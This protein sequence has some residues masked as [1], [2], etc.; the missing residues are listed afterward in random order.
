[1]VQQHETS[2]GPLAV[3]GNRGFRLYWLGQIVSL[4]GGW[5]QALAQS[6]VT[7][8]LARGAFALGAVN[9]VSAIPGALL[10]LQ[11]GVAAD[12]FDK[13]R[14]LIATQCLFM[15][16]A[17]ALA[18]LLKT[19]HLRFWHILLS[20]GI[21]GIAFAFDLPASQAL[22]PDL[23]EREH[24]PAAVQLNQ[25]IFHGSRLIGPG[26]A[27]WLIGNY[28]AYSAFV[29]N[30][31]SFLPV[32]VTLMVIRPIREVE[33]TVPRSALRAMREGFAYVRVRPQLLS[34]LGLTALTTT[35]V[36][37][38]F[39]ILMPFYVKN[40]LKLGATEVG[41]TM[42]SGGFGAFVGASAL[43]LVPVG[44]RIHRI[45][46]GMAGIVSGMLVLYAA[47]HLGLGAARHLPMWVA[48]LVVAALTALWLSRMRSWRAWRA[49]AA[50]IL[51]LGALA[52]AVARPQATVG[53]GLPD[54]LLIACAGTAM[55]SFSVSSALGMGATILQETVPDELRGRV[56][57]LQ[58][59]VFVGIMPFSALIIT[60]LVD[61][62][63]MPVELL[64]GAILYAALGAPLFRA[65]H[66]S[67]GAASATPRVP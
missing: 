59:L 65:L 18:F 25:A 60:K 54:H 67:H 31:V 12:R 10:M 26:L 50:A 19:G 66:E 58:S 57:S 1:M 16:S 4:V 62:V 8:E 64:A 9:F 13:R 45:G 53:G 47:P 36:F 38:N 33:N 63:T 40:V 56:M 28:G 39:A 55:L 37:P 24:I 61:L 23:V 32:I 14:I 42:S 20:A 21:L 22:V 6:W 35:L 29:A 41:F 48:A 17:F 44:K 30:G 43:L 49:G 11:G 3:L 52:I 15:V 34:L 5:M 51:G 27:G 46:L 2:P 7:M